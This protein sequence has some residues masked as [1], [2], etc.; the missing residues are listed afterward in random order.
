MPILEE[1]HAVFLNYHHPDVPLQREDVA[2]YRYHP[3]LL[4]AA[5]LGNLGAEDQQILGFGNKT[6]Y[7]EDFERSVQ[8]GLFQAVGLGLFNLKL[9]AG[10]WGERIGARLRRLLGRCA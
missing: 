6:H 9:R 2:Y 5:F 8:H 3:L 10:Y 7:Q 4:N 1:R